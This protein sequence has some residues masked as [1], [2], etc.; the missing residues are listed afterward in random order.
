MTELAML[1]FLFT[2]MLFW[3]FALYVIFT[4]WFEK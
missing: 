3:A 1:F 4:I 2:G